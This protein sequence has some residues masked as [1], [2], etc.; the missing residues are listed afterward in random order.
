MAIPDARVE[1]QIDGVWTPATVRH[2]PGITHTRGRRSRGSTAD[3][4]E[5][6]LTL[7]SPGG[8]YDNRN[9]RSPYY[10]RLGRNTPLRLTVDSGQRALVMGAGGGASTPD[11]PPLDIV[12]DTDVR[13]EATL[14][15]WLADGSVELAGKGAQATNQRSWLLLMRDRRVRIEWSTA[16]TSTLGATSTI[17]LPVPPS[18]RLAIRA[19]LDV[20]NGAA[21]STVT[22]YTAPSIAGPWTPLGAPVV[23]AGT[24]SV[25]ASTSPV[26]VGDGWGDLGFP[27]A[28]GMV[29]AFELRAGA[30]VVAALDFSAQ[31]EG[32]TSFTDSAGRPWTVE[33]GSTV[34]GRRTRAVAEV[35]KW[36]PRWHRSGHNVTVPIT[37]AGLLRRLEAGRGDLESTLRRRIPSEPSVRA[38]WPMED[39]RDATQAYSPLSGV[40][41]LAV[42]GLDFAA[43][44]S[45]VGS[46]ALPRLSSSATLTGTVPT[47][48]A[49]GEWMVTYVCFI[50]TPAGG[51]GPTQLLEFTTTGT[52]R[53]V[54]VAL[55]P[56]NAMRL[57]GVNAAGDVV[58]NLPFSPL[59]EFFDRWIRLEAIAKPAPAPGQVT[60]HL[61]YMNISGDGYFLGTDIAATSGVV[62]SV[63]TRFDATAA[64]FSVGHLGVLSSDNTLAYEFAD[65]GFRG[66]AAS[67][68]ITRL[69][70]EE[71]VPQTV[72]SGDTVP[73]GP[74][75]PGQLLSLLEEA[76]AAD[77]GL[78][79]E[80]A[81]ALA[82][83]YRPRV[84]L[85]NQRPALMISYEQ[86]T[87]PFEPVEEDTVRNSV[88][89]SRTG[90]SSATVE[91]DTGPLS[92]APPPAGIGLYEEAVALS[93]FHDGQ[94][95]QIAAW[96]LAQ[97]TWDEYRYPR[98]RLLLHRFPE[99]APA[100]C[101]L[102]EGDIIRITNLPDHLPP[103]PLDLMAL[104]W[105]ETFG[106]FEWVVDFMCAPGGPWTVAVAEDPALGRPDTEGSSLSAPASETQTAL[107]V[108][109]DSGPRWIDSAGYGAM[110][111]FDLAI[112]GEH[113]TATA[114][115][116]RAD[117]FARTL[118]GTWGTSTS[119]QA[120]ME[121]GGATSDRT[122]ASG[123]GVITLAANAGSIR[124]QTITGP[125]ADAEVRVRMSV[126][127]VATGAAYIPGIALR[128]VSTSVFYRAR[129]HFG[130]AGALSVSITRGTTQV[131][132][133]PA[134]PYTY[135]AGSELE[136]HVRLVGHTVQM[137]V[138]PVGQPEP[139]DWTHTVT[140]TTDTIE[141]GELGLT[142][143]AFNGNTNTAPEL[144]FDAFE[145]ITPQL[146]TV[147]RSANGVIKAHATGAP[148]NLAHPM[149]TAL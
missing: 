36:E 119:G 34:T 1:L 15:N 103:G 139:V 71:G 65:D 146:A 27:S 106:E 68:R 96:R 120:W 98:L 129:V 134:L 4:A 148:V 73:M 111:P 140:I 124:F 18:R 52:V 117:T 109:T 149:R 42:T 127:A 20:D 63:R 62:A 31:A 23:T 35:P 93:L 59:E 81:T 64:G 58:L 105:S 48:P 14:D 130:L 39:D 56:P 101:M 144:R 26:R 5:V 19:A 115:V 141:A 114:I 123:R 38:Y 51:A 107:E 7:D 12:G 43:D 74:Q 145:I 50:P 94:L 132:S 100:V 79:L 30:T 3:A 53:R 125:V 44:S 32:A 131:G 60:Y 113:V 37:A 138:W 135:T 121:V 99:L 67:G 143:S 112:A 10:Q 28:A 9:P 89:V 147:V 21:G 82:L 6:G 17:D 11:A 29:H 66:E 133:A 83:S 126:S 2:E 137:R 122:V 97:S 108:Q 40:A 76:E 70:A 91:Q 78:L 57:T 136:V 47:H 84:S 95:E 22:F 87:Q 61:G 128:A 85:Y 110:F 88:T 116:N 80:Q 45:L 24:T 8:L 54:T 69:C 33:A 49:T 90:G 104:G 77:G 41:P 92:T 16:G 75:R 118:S 102:R 142:A 13:V 55:E 25:F 46:S 72:D 86:L